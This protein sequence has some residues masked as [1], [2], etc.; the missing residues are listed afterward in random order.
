MY[1]RKLHVI[2]LIVTLIV[3]LSSSL[4][5]QVLKGSISGS[6]TDPQGAVVASAKVKATN[7]ATGTVLT[8]TSDGSGLFR[9][10]LIPAGE[11]KVEV[12]SQGFNS[13]V[14]NNVGVTAGRDTG[15]GMIKLIIGDLW[16]PREWA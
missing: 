10:N 6:V 13:A 11:Y 7:A 14:Q 5:G 9:F 16:P 1:V 4:F 3:A 8:T 15:L 12:S 2:K